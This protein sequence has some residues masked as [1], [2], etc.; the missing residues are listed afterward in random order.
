MGRI[1]RDLP[2]PEAEH[3]RVGEVGQQEDGQVDRQR[4]ELVGDGEAAL[5]R[6][7]AVER[8]DDPA[9][10]RVRLDEVEAED[11]DDD[12]E[13][14]QRALHPQ[15]RGRLRRAGPEFRRLLLVLAHGLVPLS[16]K[17]AARAARVSLRVISHGGGAVG[18]ARRAPFATGGR[19]RHSADRPR[20]L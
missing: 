6:A 19:C 12:G 10:D 11:V 9:D 1:V 4:E 18:P 14:K 5:P 17:K 15:A 3:L 16:I 8:A 13:R 20:L 2:Q 7:G